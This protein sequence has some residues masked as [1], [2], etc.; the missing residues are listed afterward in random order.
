M[1]A[2]PRVTRDDGAREPR[3]LLRM[4]AQAGQNVVAGTRSSPDESIALRRSKQDVDASDRPYLG[5]DSPCLSRD[6][7]LGNQ[8]HLDGGID[9]QH[10][11]RVSRIC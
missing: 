4:L 1:P 5:G 8:H 6:A 10:R 3:R 2:L 7:F 11:D 9:E